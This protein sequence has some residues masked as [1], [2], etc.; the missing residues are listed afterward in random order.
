MKPSYT[1]LVVK[2]AAKALALHP[3]MNSIMDETSITLFEEI[4]VGI[5]VALDDGLVV[6]VIRDAQGRDLKSIAQDAKRLATAAREGRLGMD[7]MHGGTF[8]ITT[9]GMFGVDSFTPILNA[10]QTGIL[11]VNQITDGVAWDGDRPIRR[12]VMNLSLTWD[13]RVVDGEPAA[14][15]LANVRDLLEAPYRLLV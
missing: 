9:L 5:A 7:E 2:A 4:H 10:G 8:T 13:H 14:R 11:G 3:K 6:P 12:Q 1:D 15:F